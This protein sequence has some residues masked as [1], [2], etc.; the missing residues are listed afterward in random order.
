MNRHDYETLLLAA[1]LHDTGA[2]FG[3][4][5]PLAVREIESKP[6][7]AAILALAETCATSGGRQ[8]SHLVDSPLASIFSYLRHHEMDHIPPR[9]FDYTPL[10]AT[11]SPTADY[12]FPVAKP[13]NS[14]GEYV[15]GFRDAFDPLMQQTA[16]GSFDTR[17]N[18][19]VSL[20]H[21]F[22]WCL[23][24]HEDDV[25]LYDHVRL[26]TAGAACLLQ[27]SEVAPQPDRPFV[28]AVGD[29]SGIQDYIFNI[30]AIGAAGAS[31]RLRARSFC[32]A[33]I[34]DLASH[35]LADR[36]DLPLT[37]VLM[38]SG[39]KFYVLVPNL[40]DTEA[41]LASF[42]RDVDEW[43]YREYHAEIALNLAHLS[44][45]ARQFNASSRS[46][47]GFG[48]FIARLNQGLATA[49]NRRADAIL[50]DK[51]GWL[52]DRFTL[53]VDYGGQSDCVSCGKFPATERDRLCRQCAR[54]SWL[55]SKLTRATAIA[56]FRDAGMETCDLRFLSEYCV[57]VLD[58]KELANL[59][60]S[61][62]LIVQ[63]NDPDLSAMF[64]FPATFRYL[65]N[66]VPRGPDDA[67]ISFEEVAAKCRGRELVGYV[68]ADADH[69][70]RLLAEGLRED[71]ETSRDSAV[72]VMAFSRELDLFF[73]GWLE[74]ALT[75]RFSDFYTV[76][77]GGDDLF[78]L[79][80]WSQTVELAAEVN[81]RFQQ[82]AC[83]NPAV[84]LSAGILFGKPRFPI[85]RAAEDVEHVLQEAK[86]TRNCLTVLGD[87]LAWDQVPTV[88]R[89]SETLSGFGDQ[90][91]RSAFLYRL[92][93]YGEMYQQAKHAAKAEAARYKSHFAYT[94]ARNLRGGD[95][96]LLGWA[97]WLIESL[98][99]SQPSVTM[100]HLGLI[101][102][103]VLFARRTG[104]S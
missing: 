72:H 71:D 95:P 97:Q 96:A 33:L 62:Y 81:S 57:R 93:D 41:K 61:P 79:G 7:L 19:L 44:F 21:R 91:L 87:T 14:R 59:E 65:A 98:F 64:P 15:T 99:T 30:A 6:A 69:L 16:R 100:E 74:H 55:G 63:I 83:R 76:F 88:L 102:T 66:H 53:G 89:E 26:T 2:L 94:V 28:L 85:R 1:L 43:L 45:N 101:A 78:V 52:E 54:Q 4:D 40:P 58:A 22:A 48:A 82:F 8:H 34:S 56:F 11:S 39:G 92:V 36:F 10:A 73:S 42:R 50:Q 47:E 77:S 68:K 32:I 70:G 17:F 49:K 13:S 25:C 12:L 27:S 31:R 3:T 38:S 5:A 104:R 18:H 103:T 80:P 46:E 23:P 60:G 29:L 24:A 51:S 84:S 90:A 9:Y 67:P 20:F 35:A 75:N 86:R 37:N